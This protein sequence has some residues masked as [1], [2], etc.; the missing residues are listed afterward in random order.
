MAREAQPD[1]TKLNQ[2]DRSDGMSGHYFH[3]GKVHM[4]NHRP[5]EAIA[6]FR[7]AL[8]LQPDSIEIRLHLAQAL[9]LGGLLTE[10]VDLCRDA[11][12][13]HPD[14]PHW[15][16][17]LGQVYLAQSRPELALTHF[18]TALSMQPDLVPAFQGLGHAYLQQGQGPLA[19]EALHQAHQLHPNNPET[20]VSLGLA[21]Q[22]AGWGDAARRSLQQAL[23]MRPVYFD[24]HFHLGNIF[25]NQGNFK[26]AGDCYRRAVKIRKG[27]WEAWA[28]LGSALLKQGCLTE[29]RDCFHRAVQIRPQ[30]P[31]LGVNLAT[32]LHHLGEM[33]AALELYRRVIATA[34]EFPEAWLN[35]G[36]IWHEQSHLD[37][38]EAAYRQALRL[39]PEFPEALT[40]LGI[41]AHKRG[42]LAAALDWFRAAQNIRPDCAVAHY[43]ESLTLLA[44][45]DYNS[46]WKKYEWRWRTEKFQPLPFSGP[47][48]D[49]APAQNITLLLLCE[50]GFGDS[51]QFIRYVSL[52]KERVGKIVLF[53]P[54]SL[55]RLFRTMSEID[56]L[57]SVSDGLP[58][59]DCQA[60]LMSLPGLLN[61]TLDTIPGH[62]PY[63]TT[64][65]ADE[66]KFS[67]L[68]NQLPGLK[69]GLTWRGNPKH[70]N[71]RHRS[72]NPAVMACLSRVE[73]CC[74][75]NLQKEISVEERSV[76]LQAG[77]F[78]DFMAES[79]DFA[80]TA[81][82][83]AQLDLVISVDTAVIHLAGALAKPC[84]LLLPP[85]ADWRW[86]RQRDHSPWY[87]TLRLFRRGSRED[88]PT[89][90]EQV[91]TSLREWVQTGNHRG[92]HDG[93]VQT[94]P[95]S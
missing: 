50:Q 25:M 22:Q 17:E 54:P 47:S 51:I 24:A 84:W 80:D 64:N 27:S 43:N 92:D 82:L 56:F 40:G 46:G 85:I 42:E 72:L 11:S 21:L 23:K 3:G 8:R 26:A 15:H 65:A 48:W 75:I 86:L 59:W 71:D 90:M 60:S 4:R 77:N 29:A 81:A 13:A 87:P 88:W 55:E 89:T 91:M 35:L 10:A 68:L 52:V 53:C 36:H 63:L 44:T 39:R 20:L 78:Y 12:T 41:V 34:P 62:I 83:I 9:R 32:V 94:P 67:L 5:A 69:I 1:T 28:N 16:L 70:E 76:W 33:D 74:F 18:R 6:A 95:G 30:E 58:P 14:Q 93:P 61:T 7:E 66:K 73:G 19:A 38:A 45:G 31:G 2:A 49:G 37:E 57:T 79:T